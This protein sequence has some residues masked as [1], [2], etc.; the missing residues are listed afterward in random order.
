MSVRTVLP[1]R[2]ILI[3]ELYQR[4]VDRASRP[5]YR[6]MLEKLSH[7]SLVQTYALNVELR[8]Q[9]AEKQPIQE[10]HCFC[11]GHL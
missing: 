9:Q 2:R 10:E 11:S 1:I 8:P 6:E 7:K 4:W 3:D 5:R